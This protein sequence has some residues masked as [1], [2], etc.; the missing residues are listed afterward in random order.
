MDP[1]FGDYVPIRA[2][3]ALVIDKPGAIALR[4][5]PCPDVPGECKI[6]VRRAGICG[7]DLELLEGYANFRGIP[8]HEF[9]GAVE[10]VPSVAE[11]AWFR[12]RVVGEINVGCGA[13][14]WCRRGVREHCTSRSVVGI[15]GRA[16]AFAEFLWLPAANLH[17]L[18]DSLS[19]EAAVF[20]EPTAAACRI[21]EQVA[22]HPGTRAA[23]LGDGRLGLLIAQVLRTATPHVMVFGR[24]DRKLNVARQLG[25]DAARAGEHRARFD[26]VVDAT[27]APDGLASAIDL[28]TPRGTV[29]LKSTTHGD[30][31]LATWPAVVN[32]VTIVGSRCGP[33]APAIDLLARRAVDVRPLISGVFPLKDHVRAF[34]A[35]RHG[36]K[37]LFVTRAPIR[38][39]KG[40]G[41][42]EQVMHGGV[43]HGR[44]L[45]E[46]R[47][48]T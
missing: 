48:E 18:P 17:A 6:R 14:D 45:P 19:D 35:A 25:L 29:V 1:S 22:I 10:Q 16:G 47:A 13:C 38:T 9:V 33:F 5:V 26:V 8:G 21:L 32:E 34:D 44:H 39:S 40:S 11:A 15:R 7:T 27:G 30:A 36:L 24:H 23:V 3:R 31:A 20:V 42:G 12:K 46:A 4:D 41:R 2:M 43:V 28:V 37:V